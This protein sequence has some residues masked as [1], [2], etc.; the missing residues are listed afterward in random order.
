MNLLSRILFF[1]LTVLYA[2]LITIWNWYW[3]IAPKVKLSCKVISVGNIVAGGTGKTPL[4][5]Y[6]AGIARASGL[7]TAVVARGYR[8]RGK[9][10]LEVT[11]NSAWDMVGDEPMEIFQSVPGLRVYVCESKT[12]AA[13]KAFEDGAEIIIVDD[14]FQHRKL[15]RN[16]D[17]VCLDSNR[18]FGPGG[19]LPGGRLREPRGALNRANA[20]MFTS[21]DKDNNSIDKLSDMGRYQVFHSNSEIEHFAKL[22]DNS[23]R[24][25]EFISSQKS[26]AFCGLGNPEKFKSSLSKA[27]IAPLKFKYYADHHSYSNFD[28]EMLIALAKQQQADCLV[29][30][31]KDAVKLDF[32]DFGEMPVYYS[33]IKISISNEND[34]RKLL[35]L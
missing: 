22:G 10:L 15:A 11:S 30:T 20:L 21:Y 12:N 25:C 33:Q 3:Q 16:I 28:F 26:I 27:G 13:K 24:D 7:K 31:H 18:P 23:V 19:L 1:P 29:T 9:G 4:V 8:R 6:I 14:G 2:A 32:V 35:G 17:I 34:F 5:I